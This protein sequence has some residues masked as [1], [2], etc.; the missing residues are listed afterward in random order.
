MVR[1]NERG[2]EKREAKEE[3][4][5]HMITP[6]LQLDK[7]PTLVTP[8][9]TIHRRQPHRILK[10]RIP[11]TVPP[12]ML[13]RLANG[14]RLAAALDAGADIHV[15]L[16][17]LRGD[18]GRTRRLVAVRAVGRL[19]LDLLRAELPDERR[20][21]EDAALRERDGMP[22]APGWEERLV[23]ECGLEER[24]QAIAAVFVGAEGAACEVEEG[25]VF[26]AGDALVFFLGVS[27]VFAG[28][29]GGLFGLLS[30]GCG[31]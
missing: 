17:E 20:G 31:P 10:R 29:G 26:L 19:Q 5:T 23:G 28:V 25:V 12:A 6:R 1:E 11:G 8:L 13:G 22:A 27:V 16:D 18:K 9:P 7:T 3:R 24:G 4:Q 14:A 15:P 21:E 2:E 30:S